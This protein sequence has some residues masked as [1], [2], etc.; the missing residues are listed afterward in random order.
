MNGVKPFAQGRE[1]AGQQ[2]GQLGRIATG[3]LRMRAPQQRGNQRPELLIGGRTDALGDAHLGQ[4]LG[5]GAAQE[6][7]D[8]GRHA[9]RVG[10]V[11]YALGNSFC[12]Q[13]ACF[14]MLQRLDCGIAP[15]LRRAR[16]VAP[17]LLQAAE[18]LL[19]HLGTLNRRTEQR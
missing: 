3:Q 18:L 9:G 7:N 1:Q 11:F 17:M 12:E 14:G 15:L 8:H 10:M 19:K 5:P 6:V 4:H 13:I 2:A 16:V